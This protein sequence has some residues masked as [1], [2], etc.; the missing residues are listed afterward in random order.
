M[1][2]LPLSL[3]A[4]ILPSRSLLLL[5]SETSS[6]TVLARAPS[7]AAVPVSAPTARPV[8][9]VAAGSVMPL[10]STV[11]SVPVASDEKLRPVP[12]VFSPT[13]TLTPLSS[14]CCWIEAMAV[15]RSAPEVSSRVTSKLLVPSDTVKAAVS[16]A[17]SPVNAPPSA[18]A[19]PASTAVTPGLATSSMLTPV[20]PIAPPDRVRFCWVAVS[21]SLLML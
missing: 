13:V 17:A 4:R 14:S 10:I 16:P 18:V 20:S 2:R 6:S 5:I 19:A 3:D 9:P 1:R 7:T 12:A 8:S 21:R 15:S 11:A